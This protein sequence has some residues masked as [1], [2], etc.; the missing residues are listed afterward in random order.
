MLA[1]FF[2]FKLETATAK[3]PIPHKI[4]NYAFLT[5]RAKNLWRHASP[6]RT[7]GNF[8]SGPAVTKCVEASGFCAGACGDFG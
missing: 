8:L 2:A 4:N 5:S 6:G 1:T 7:G 3:L